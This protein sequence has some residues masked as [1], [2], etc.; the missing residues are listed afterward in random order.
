MAASPNALGGILVPPGRGVV[1][2]SGGSDSVALLRWILETSPS[3]GEVIVGHLNHQLRGA[4]SDQDA[5]FVCE[6]AA[7]LKCAVAC[8][9]V[10]VARQA[11]GKNLEATARKLRYEFL[12]A[13]AKAHGATWIATGHTLD[14]Q[15]ETV[16]HRLLRGAGLQGLR[17]IAPTRA[18]PGGVMLIRPLLGVRKSALTAYLSR[19]GQSHR[20]DQTNR[21]DAFTRNRL[22]HRILPILEAESA[23]AVERLGRLATNAAA[24]YADWEVLARAALS[25]ARMA[26][27]VGVRIAADALPQEKTLALEMYRLLWQTEGWPLG[28]M[29]EAHWTQLHALMQTP[30]ARK[31]FPGCL[32]AY[33]RGSFIELRLLSGC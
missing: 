21:D 3:P 25:R 20:E 5:E 12:E 32:H 29:T 9:A 15:A 13:T 6:L 11:Q 14:D 2:V 18:L 30:G 31:D 1:A 4:Q 23:L 27:E 16:L 19:L 10:D 17:G 8:Q 33:H 7:T 24:W 28:D 22:R 26:T